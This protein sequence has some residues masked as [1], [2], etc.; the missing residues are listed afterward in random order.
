MTP[1][2]EWVKLPTHWILNRG[3]RAITWNKGGSAHTAALM[4]LITM[5]HYADEETG[6]VKVTYG[7]LHDV[8][9]LSRTSISSGLGVLEALGVVDAC[10]ERSTFR[11][12]QYGTPPWGKLPAKGL[13]K[14]GVIKAFS[15]FHLRHQN[16]LRALK[17]FLVMIASRDN[18]TNMA[19]IGYDAISEKTGVPKGAIKGALN[20]LVLH[21]LIHVERI[22]KA[23]ER[24]TYTAYRIA[25]VDPYRHMGT[26]GRGDRIQEA[27][28]G[29]SN[30]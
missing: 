13:Y 26:I 14:E 25:H 23:D 1:R 3:L 29:T 18:A 27:D 12:S 15:H 10:E 21:Q 9:G 2:R 24:R 19:A 7:Q 17:I 20:L 11:I 4:L 5:A 8:T 6:L 22:P 30:L 16:E 28:F